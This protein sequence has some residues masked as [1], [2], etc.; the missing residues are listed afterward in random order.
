MPDP[1]RTTLGT[2]IPAA[3]ALA[4]LA[5]RPLPVKTAYHVSK[6]TRLVRHELTWYQTERDAA[7]KAHGAPRQPTAEE[8]AA[9]TV[10]PVWQ[11]GDDGRA[12]FFARMAELD[13]LPVE[14]AWRP[15][16]LDALDGHP[17]TAAD[18]T[19]LVTAGLLDD[20]D[21]KE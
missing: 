20:T 19:A 4:R 14:L 3:P 5:D 18:V 8:A 16:A 21:L 10:G 13:D 9:G 2:L 6:L 7:I 1:I 17:I 11:V 12:A 15:L